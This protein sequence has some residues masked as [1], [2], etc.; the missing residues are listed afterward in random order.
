MLLEAFRIQIAEAS[1]RIFQVSRKQ[2]KS[3]WYR[4]LLWAS[5]RVR[6][7]EKI[8]RFCRFAFLAVINGIPW[9]IFYSMYQKVVMFDWLDFAPAGEHDTAKPRSLSV[10]ETR[11]YSMS[12]IQGV[13]QF[14]S[15]L[16]FKSKRHPY[17]S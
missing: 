11:I 12:N 15:V 10:Y 8:I 7:P 16:L 5:T 1:R 9:Y 6:R 17:D 13:V 3:A 4:L 2:L 14:F